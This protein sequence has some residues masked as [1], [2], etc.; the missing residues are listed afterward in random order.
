MT[1]DKEKGFIQG[2]VYACGF[3]VEDHDLPTLA[4]ELLNETGF[5]KEDLR[6]ANEYDLAKCRKAIPGLPKGKL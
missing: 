4:S 1:K 6:F 3:L 5:S 2:V